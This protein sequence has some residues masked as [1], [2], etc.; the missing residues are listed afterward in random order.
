MLAGSNTI[1]SGMAQTILDSLCDQLIPV[2][3]SDGS[4]KMLMH[5]E[6]DVARFVISGG[7]VPAHLQDEVTAWRER[8]GV[9]AANR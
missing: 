2:W 3:F 8:Y 6:N 4:K 5:P 7:P 9:F 1:E